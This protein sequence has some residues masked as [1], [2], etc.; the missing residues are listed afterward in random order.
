MKFLSIVDTDFFVVDHESRIV[1]AGVTVVRL[2]VFRVC[3]SVFA[4]SQCKKFGFTF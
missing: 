2:V 1:V 4:K 3:C